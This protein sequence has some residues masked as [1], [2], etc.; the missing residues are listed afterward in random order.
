MKRGH[1]AVVR[2]VATMVA[3]ARLT[4]DHRRRQPVPLA[5]DGTASIDAAQVDAS[6]LS[7]QKKRVGN[8]PSQSL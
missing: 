1:P 3:R 2:S 5:L 4:R 8:P 6:P 7:T